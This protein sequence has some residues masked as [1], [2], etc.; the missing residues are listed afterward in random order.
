MAQKLA[1]LVAIGVIAIVIGESEAI[2][3]YSCAVTISS[4]CLDPFSKSGVATCDGEAC[5][6]SIASAAGT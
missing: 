1:A 3:C 5:T 4:S 2:Q 6:K